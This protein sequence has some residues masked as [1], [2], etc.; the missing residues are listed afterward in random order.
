VFFAVTAVFCYAILFQFW[1]VC[2][3]IEQDKSFS[4]ENVRSFLLMSKLLI[5]LAVLWTVCLL[6]HLIC[7][8][9]TFEVIWHIVLIIFVWGVI[10][11]LC[12]ALAVLIEK[13]VRL[14]EEQELTI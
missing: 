13:A 1:K 4:S 7:G 2:L 3:Q 9:A 8:W 11:G 12:A 14:Q 10:A 6:V 5:V